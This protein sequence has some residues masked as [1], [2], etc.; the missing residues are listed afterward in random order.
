ML[1]SILMQNTSLGFYPVEFTPLYVGCPSYFNNTDPPLGGGFVGEE[2]AGST[3]H[4]VLLSCNF[5]HKKCIV[6]TCPTIQMNYSVIALALP[7]DDSLLL[8]KR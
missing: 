8:Q 2:P 5:H 6:C 7:T 4:T 1:G 3:T